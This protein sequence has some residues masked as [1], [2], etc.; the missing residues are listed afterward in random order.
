MNVTALNLRMSEAER[1]ELLERSSVLARAR[2]LVERLDR[3]RVVRPS[4]APDLRGLEKNLDAVDRFRAV[5]DL[6]GGQIDS[7]RD[8]LDVLVH[9]GMIATLREQVDQHRDG[10]RFV[11]D[12]SSE[13][14]SAARQRVPG[15]DRHELIGD[16]LHDV[17]QK[18]GVLQ[19]VAVEP[20]DQLLPAMHDELLGERQRAQ[21]LE[22]RG[23]SSSEL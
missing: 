20:F 18:L 5:L 3:E 10:E 21:P 15:D 11:E 23:S 9:D 14:T 1:Q 13:F 12:G 7:F 2:A 6:T 16:E 8:F 19:L 17:A 4:A 22:V